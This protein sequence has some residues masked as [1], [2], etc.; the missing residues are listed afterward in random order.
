MMWGSASADR[1]INGTQGTVLRL[2]AHFGG[3]G[4][5]LGLGCRTAVHP[6]LYDSGRSREACFGRPSPPVPMTR[7]AS[8]ARAHRPAGP[9]MPASAG[10]AHPPGSHG[11]ASA[12]TENPVGASELAS[13]S[14]RDPEPAIPMPAS[15]GTALWQG[16]RRPMPASAGTA[17]RREGTRRPLPRSTDHR[18]R[19]MASRPSG[20]RPQR[21][22]PMWVPQ[23]LRP[24]WKVPPGFRRPRSSATVASVTARLGEAR[25]PRLP[26][27]PHPAS[28]FGREAAL[29]APAQAE[30][31]GD[32]RQRT[33]S[34]RTSKARA[35]GQVGPGGWTVTAGR[36]RP[37]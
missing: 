22:R 16:P 26:G 37:Q 14:P 20:K 8:A 19:P 30:P 31:R 18:L 13:A 34:R 7:T 29:G 28:F 9:P 25:R 6:A 1:S 32:V 4:A 11:P 5:R 12:G 17:L 2:R 3:N 15:A 35:T 24:M 21:L 10:T 36:Q 23:R 33:C 27:G